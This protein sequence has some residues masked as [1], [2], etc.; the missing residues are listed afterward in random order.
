M[1]RP[2]SARPLRRRYVNAK[3]PLVVLRFEDG[4]EIQLKRGDGK[5]FDAYAGETIKVVVIWDAPA[6]DREVI[7]VMKAEQFEEGQ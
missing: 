2:P 7:A 6:G 4:H 5:S 3:H 1:V